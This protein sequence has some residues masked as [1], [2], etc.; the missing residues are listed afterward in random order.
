[1]I[2]LEL[3]DHYDSGYFVKCG[4]Y[5]L[6]NNQI[7]DYEVHGGGLVGSKKSGLFTKARNKLSDAILLHTI[8]VEE[9]VKYIFNFENYDLGDFI[10]SITLQKELKEYKKPSSVMV[11]QLADR[12]YKSFEVPM[13]KGTR[14]SYL[15]VWS[16]YVL[17]P[18][19]KS[20]SELDIPYYEGILNTLLQ[21]FGLEKHIKKKRRQKIKVSDKDRRLMDFV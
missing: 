18:E 19:V 4:N 15:K 14:Y 7:N 20:I 12:A 3:E 8:K 11:C 21:A 17:V 5:I 16:G 9:T 6:W 10:Q 2:K 1:M 13:E